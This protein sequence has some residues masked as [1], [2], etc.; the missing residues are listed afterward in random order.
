MIDCPYCHA[1][2]KLVYGHEHYKDRP[3]L[4]HAAFWT[5]D[6]CDAR[7][8]CHKGTTKPLGTMANM[9]LR[10]LRMLAHKAFD[11]VWIGGKK[12]RSIAYRRMAKKLGIKENRCHIG[13]FDVDMCLRVIE[14]YSEVEA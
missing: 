8:G 2:A 3:D 11:K 14:I 13:E 9:R 12:K 7:V 5:C 1:P 6:P 10:K 4:Y